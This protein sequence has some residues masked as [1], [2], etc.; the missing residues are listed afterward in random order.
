MAW[1]ILMWMEDLQMWMVPAD[2]LN[3]QFLTVN[4]GWSFGLWVGWGAI[5][6]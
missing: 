5:L 2:I 1:H 4:E 3:K 6:F